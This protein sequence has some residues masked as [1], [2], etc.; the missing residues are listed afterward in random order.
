MLSYL[1]ALV[2]CALKLIAIALL[3]ATPLRETET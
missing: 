2:P 1:Y 3:V